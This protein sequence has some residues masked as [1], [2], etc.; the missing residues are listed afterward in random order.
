MIEARTVTSIEETCTY[1][2]LL[3]IYL[4]QGVKDFHDSSSRTR[5]DPITGY[6]PMNSGYNTSYHRKKKTDFDCQKW[7]TIP[8]D[9]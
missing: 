3:R 2:Y 6:D 9:E 4:S 1:V 5:G 8:D 7:D